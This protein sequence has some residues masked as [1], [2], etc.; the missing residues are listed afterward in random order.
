MRTLM[1]LSISLDVGG[2]ENL[3]LNLC[4]HIDRERFRPIVC[5]LSEG[6]ALQKEFE[7]IGVPVYSVPKRDGFDWQLI[8]PLVSL[9]RLERVDILHT[10]NACPY[11]YGTVA[12][13]WSGVSAIV[14]TEHSNI[15]PEHHGLWRVERYLSYLANPIIADS[16]NVAETLIQDQ[17]VH[18]RRVKVIPN[19]IDEQHF[20][21]RP[22]DQA[23]QESFGIQAG[24]HV[25]GIVARLEP[26]KN[27][28][29]L[30]RA[31]SSLCDLRSDIRLLIVGDGSSRSDLGAMA[32]EL[33]IADRI[34][35]AGNRRDIPEC[36]SLMDAFALSSVS[37]GLPL[38]I[39]EAMAAGVP[40]ISTKV[41]GIPEVINNE[42]NGLLVESQ[43]VAGMRDAFLRLLEDTVLTQQITS[44]ARSD[45]V[46][47]YSLR[48]MTRAY[49]H[50]YDQANPPRPIPVRHQE[51]SA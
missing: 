45:V 5:C 41:G 34:I 49:E 30:L 15:E 2:L 46:S 17:S 3:I 7:A 11:L 12:G 19:G 16:E 43:D 47:R 31:F 40:V 24:E 37:E 33:N 29:M 35:F 23:L 38:T 32:Q 44:C 42:R 39:L 26:V 27:H 8:P 21:P 13:R 51:A 9:L 25:I 4:Q 36:L 48:A 1:H 14:H 22:P 6:L 10:H 50:T 28:Q 18:P 20:Q